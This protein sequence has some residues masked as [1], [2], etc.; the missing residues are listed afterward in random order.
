VILFSVVDGKSI[1]HI[2]EKWIPEIFKEV[3]NPKFIF[4]ANKIDLLENEGEMKKLKEKGFTDE[5]MK[6]CIQYL[7]DKYPE[8][9]FLEISCL[10]KI[11][12]EEAMI[13]G[14]REVLKEK[15]TTKKDGC[16]IN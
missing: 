12:L 3:E 1:H 13:L 5:E 8:T 9:P 10:N 14:Y 11:N 15:Q 6:S 2:T 4:I 7:R 16:F